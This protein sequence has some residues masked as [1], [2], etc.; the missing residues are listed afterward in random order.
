MAPEKAIYTNLVCSI[1]FRLGIM[2]IIC[3]VV[4][5]YTMAEY[6][7]HK[8]TLI[9]GDYLICDIV[10]IRLFILM[11]LWEFIFLTL[12]C[13]EQFKSLLLFPSHWSIQHSHHMDMMFVVHWLLNR[14]ESIVLFRWHGA[15]TFYLPIKM[16]AQNTRN[17]KN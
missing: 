3:E 11:L 6:L 4:E 15:I 14:S 5:R 9:L 13:F 12:I 17:T 7:C 16:T 8:S 1:H 10:F 2:V